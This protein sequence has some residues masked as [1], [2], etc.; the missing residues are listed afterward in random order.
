MRLLSAGLLYVAISTVM[1]VLLGEN[2]GGLSPGVSF[3]SLIAGAATALATFFLMPPPP[4]QPTLAAAKEDPILKYRSIWLC[5]VGFVFAMFAVRSFCWLLFFA[6]ENINIQSPFNL[7]DLGLHITYVKTFANGV[8]MWPESPIYVYSQLRYPAGIDLFNG[9]LTNLGFDL[10][11][12]LVATGLLA[13]LATFYALYRWGGTFTVAGFLFNG[14]IAGFQFLDTHKFLDYQGTSHV[15]WKSIPLT[16]FVTQRGLL[17]AIPAG[18]LLLWQ[19]RSKYDSEPGKQEQLLPVWAEYILYATMPLFHV[20]TF[21]A[22]S[23]VLLVLFLTRPDSRLPLF[24]LV[25]AAVLPAVFFV[26]LTTDRM[27]AGSILEWHFGWTQTVGDFKM[28]F[29]LFWLFN[30]GAFLPLA[31]ALVWIVAQ[32]ESVRFRS[33]K[34]ELSIDAAYLAA[35][36]LIFLLSICVKTAPWEWDNIKLLIWAYF[37]TLPLLWERLLLRWPVPARVGTCLIL[38]FSGFV[39]LIGGLAVNKDGYE[40][41]NRSEIDFVAAAVRRLPV[42]ARFAGFPT[43]NHPLLLNGRKMVCGYGGH[44]WTQGINST[45]VESKL[46]NLMLGQG[47][48][49]KAARELE[50][51]YLFWGKLEKANYVTSTK[52]WEKQLPLVAQGDWGSIYDF[53]SETKR[54]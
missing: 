44:L 2:A 12:Q 37:I 30:F 4:A 11:Q 1:A 28:E 34:L 33:G 13:S 27:R 18:L 21:I 22:L 46:R 26:W 31:I 8:A 53:G 24:K 20:H 5:L 54:Y 39:S 47:D 41:A 6:G 17:Y 25:S 36:V 48:W 19:W 29:F 43:Y 40:F 16:M 14:G 9:L 45:D 52:P 50:V 10:R 38:F 35:A 32:Q 7:G 42:E 49:K 3:V 15:S 23:I 51:R